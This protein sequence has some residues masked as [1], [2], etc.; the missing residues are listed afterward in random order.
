[1]LTKRDVL[2]DVNFGD[3]VAEQEADNLQR[4]FVSTE[5]WRKVLS[6]NTDVI[7][8][9]KGSGKSAIYSLLQ[10]Q[11]AELS[12]RNVTFIPAENPRGA[13]AFQ[14]L[15]T[16]PPAT[17]VEFVRM[18]KLYILSLIGELFLDA[19]DNTDARFVVSHLQAAGLIQ[20]DR[21]LTDIASAT[22]RYV[23]SFFKWESAQGEVKLDPT[24]GMPAGLS[25]KIT[26]GSFK[27][28]LAKVGAI[29]VDTLLAKANAALEAM[30]RNIWVGID[31]L[32]VAFPD[33]EDLE[34]NAL[35]SLF[36]SYLDFQAYPRIVPKIFLR[37]DI[38]TRISEQGFREASHITRTLTIT[39]NKDLLL[40]LLMRRALQSSKLCEFYGIEP[41]RILE[42]I[43]SQRQLFERML[44]TQIDPGLRRPKALDW[45]LSRI[46]DGRGYEAPRELIQLFNA[47]REAQLRSIEIG[48]QPEGDAILT[49][50]SFK[51]GLKS[52]S[53]RRLYQTLFA[54]Y[55][56]LKPY[57]EKLRGQKSEHTV[58]TL[59]SIWGVD[60]AGTAALIEKLT[61]VGFFE[62]RAEKGGLSYWVPFLYRDALELLLGRAD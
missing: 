23:R 42:D 19:S 38:W 50:D 33:N 22:W 32:D 30:N 4:Y 57:I 3:S 25:G 54:E 36:K 60:D 43:V 35:R 61:N 34:A 41:G 18:W 28:E 59:K 40:N 24:T 45:V 46:R 49:G 11:A 21:S 58:T 7:Y 55:P 9:P 51:E 12:K 20:K 44:P 26:F 2:Q 29:S 52:V 56:A 62:S 39:W 16:D 48:E 17:E 13:T 14:D 6:G 37:T 1:M 8:G 10:Q 5:Q 27:P 31:R 53:E 15:V 47:T